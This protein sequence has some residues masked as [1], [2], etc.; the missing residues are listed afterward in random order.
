[1]HPYSLYFT[2]FELILFG[3]PILPE[4]LYTRLAIIAIYFIGHVYKIQ[5]YYARFKY[6]MLQHYVNRWDDPIDYNHY[7]NI[8]PF[9]I[10]GISTKISPEINTDYLDNKKGVL[11]NME[12]ID[13]NV[14]STTEICC[15]DASSDDSSV[16]SDVIV[17]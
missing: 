5:L 13:T 1:M 12:I 8:I 11:E 16:I 3:I 14:K 9:M 7:F 2:S 17:M 6:Y 15:D 10:Y 4:Q